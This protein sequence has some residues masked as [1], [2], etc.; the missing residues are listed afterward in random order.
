MVIDAT[1]LK[2]YGAGEWLVEQHG[3]RGIW[4]WRKPHPTVDPSTGKIFASELTSNENGDA[5]QVG[6]LLG[7]VP[8]P[9]ASV[10]V[11]SA[12][13]GE[14]VY[15]AVAERQPDPPATVVIPPRSTAVPSTAASTPPSLTFHRLR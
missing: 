15:R 6:L 2:V 3:R 13:D 4:T 11:D 8:G 14:P 7:Q 1:G 9:I 12:N 5:S 10:T